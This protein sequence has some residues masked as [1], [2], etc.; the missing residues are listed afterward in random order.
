VVGEIVVYGVRDIS[1][2]EGD[3]VGQSF[4]EHGRECGKCIVGPDREVRDGT[5][6]EDENGIDGGDM[7]LDLAR[8]ALFVEL[9]L[10]R[11]ASVGQPRRIEDANLRKR[12]WIFTT[13]TKAGTY[14]NAVLTLDFVKAGRVCATLIT[15]ATMLVGVVEDVGVAVVNIS[16]GK[17][18]FDKFQC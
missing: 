13:L 14:H 7:L 11:T 17:S 9:V 5:I 4:G 15:R 12:L 18:N 6:S 3:V 2:Q 8:N 16:A 1:E 10:L